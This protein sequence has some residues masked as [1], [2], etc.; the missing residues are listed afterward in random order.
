VRWSPVVLA[1]AAAAGGASGAPAQGAPS[2]AWRPEERL[3]VTDLSRV[4]A[5]AVTQAYV[6][7]ATREALAVYGRAFGELRE[8]VGRGEGYPGGPVAAMVADPSDDTAWLAGLGFW[9]AYH[10][11]GRRW[12]AGPLPGL[13]DLV[14]L[15]AADPA[16]GAYFRT[17]AGWYFVA[18][19]GAFAE[20]ALALPAAGSRIAPLGQR[21]LLAQAPGLDAVRMS[22]ERDEQLRVTP[23]TAAAVSAVRGEA[24]VGTDGNGVFR[25]DLASY[26]AERLSAGLL[27]AATGAVAVDRDRVC[28]AADPRAGAA[29]R[30]VTCFR[31]DLSDFTYLAGEG[32]AGLP[33]TRVRRM[34]LTRRAAWVAT[35]A[36]ALRLPRG[37]GRERRYLER[38]GIPSGDVRAFAPAPDGMWIGTAHGLAVATEGGS[39]EPAQP[40]GPADLEVLSLAVTDDTLW[41]GTPGGLAVLMPGSENPLI[42]RP[43]LPALRSPVLAIA[44]KGDTILAALD[45]RLALRAGGVWR[46][47]EP[48]GTPIGRFTA[49]AADA[50]GFWL[51]GEQGLAFYRPATGEWRALTSAGDLPLPVADV[52]AGGEYV[53][54]ATPGGVVRF[55]RRVLM[56]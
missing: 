13:A 41:I 21:D 43:D 34:A 54:V 29:R 42:V 35:D 51:G 20:R 7:A 52:A 17:A 5:V 50:D 19:N 45:R 1:V 56:P 27:G 26:R 44:V 46:L 4:T 12:D 15:D 49:A 36:G 30:G 2:R 28:A 8:V 39:A 23:M 48:P 24:Y 37:G 47:V 10:P 32:L 55:Q 22:I 14:A 11:F 9:A 16:R 38:D 40:V 33:G 6:F 25:V 3:L 18:K 31:S 53:W